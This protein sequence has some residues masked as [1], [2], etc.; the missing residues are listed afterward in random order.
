MGPP[1]KSAQD[2]SGAQISCRRMAA[3]AAKRPFLCQFVVV[4]LCSA[5]AYCLAMLPWRGTWEEPACGE[6]N[7][8]NEFQYKILTGLLNP[9]DCHAAIVWFGVVDRPLAM[10]NFPRYGAYDGTCTPCESDD[11]IICLAAPLPWTSPPGS[12]CSFVDLYH[13]SIPGN[14]KVAT[15]PVTMAA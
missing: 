1:P 14:Y 5:P 13:T 11:S 6:A 8:K 7:L 2:S 10:A 12:A 9:Y 4:C 3:R 15:V